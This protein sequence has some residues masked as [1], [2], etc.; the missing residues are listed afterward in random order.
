VRRGCFLLAR[1]SGRRKARVTARFLKQLGGALAAAA[2]SGS[3]TKL[4][5]EFV[6]AVDTVADAL[7]HFPLGYGIADADVQGANPMN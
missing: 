4:E 1:G 5:R 6:Q 3:D 2:A 7:A